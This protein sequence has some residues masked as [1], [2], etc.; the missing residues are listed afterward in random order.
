[1]AL[2]LGADAIAEGLMQMSGY[3]SV[4]ANR[5]EAAGARAIISGALA[6]LKAYAERKLAEGQLSDE[7]R[8]QLVAANRELEVR[9][10]WAIRA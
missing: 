2:A 1:M 10:Q 9:E 4:M 5:P 8:R 3:V 7:E 6:A